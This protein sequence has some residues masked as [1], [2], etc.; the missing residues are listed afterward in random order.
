VSGQDYTGWN[1]PHPPTAPDGTALTPDEWDAV[2]RLRGERAPAAPA[3]PASAP[4]SEGEPPQPSVAAAQ[5]TVELPP[6]D[7]WGGG[8]RRARGTRR[9]QRAGALTAVSLLLV[10][11]IAA[12][13][14]VTLV[15][16]HLSSRRTAAN[17]DTDAISAATAGV[18][19]VLSYNYRSLANDF[20]KA[21]A[22]LTPSFRKTYL[23]TTAKAVQPLAAKYK[24]V[25]SAQVTAAGV[26][27]SGAGHVQVLVFVDQTATN[28]QLAKP[29]LDRSRINV[30]LVHRGGTWLI[31]N[32][33]PV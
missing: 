10:L 20:A 24:A 31:N 18:A 7:T 32:L 19:T 17:S 6:V 21:E 4:E 15:T 14:L 23:A 9:P 3:D 25:S 12:A 26:V 22:L 5:P 1:E 33:A 2:R 16:V 28:S 30:D 11:A 13:V 8:H 27:S 29:R